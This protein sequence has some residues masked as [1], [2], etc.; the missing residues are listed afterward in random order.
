MIFKQSDILFLQV[1]VML[2]TSLQLLIFQPVSPKL[3]LE[4]SYFLRH[5]FYYPFTFLLRYKLNSK[6]KVKVNKKK[7]GRKDEAEGKLTRLKNKKAP[8]QRLMLISIENF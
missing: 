7:I 3:K 8:E 5:F 1:T 4:D 6:R 2:C